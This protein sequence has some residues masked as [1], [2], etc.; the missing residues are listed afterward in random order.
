MQAVHYSHAKNTLKSMIDKGIQTQ[1]PQHYFSPYPIKD[2]SI[3]IITI[4]RKNLP[5]R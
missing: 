4:Y 5:S 2:D 3:S 1:I